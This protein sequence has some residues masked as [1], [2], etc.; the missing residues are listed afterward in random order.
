MG[1]SVKISPSEPEDHRGEGEDV[2]TEPKVGGKRK[3]GGRDIGMSGVVRG[4]GRCSQG[5]EKGAQIDE[6]HRRE[7]EEGSVR[8]LE[9]TR[10]EGK[11]RAGLLLP[12][13]IRPLSYRLTAEIEFLQRRFEI[14]KK[15]K[16]KMSPLLKVR[17]AS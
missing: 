2:I 4:K 17:R 3:S 8:R 16:K 7:G 13:Y 11:W 1:N 14:F 9:C 6:G 12:R 15:L 5:Y 10:Q